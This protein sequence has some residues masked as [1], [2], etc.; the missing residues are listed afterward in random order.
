VKSAA[1]PANRIVE[2][3][4]KLARDHAAGHPMADDLTI[5]CVKNATEA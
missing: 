2:I 4:L 1:S 3:L 5:V